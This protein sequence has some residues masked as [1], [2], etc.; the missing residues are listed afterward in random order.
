MLFSL[1]NDEKPEN[2]SM[3]N[4]HSFFASDP[5]VI[6]EHDVIASLP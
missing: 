5:Q 2:L 6:P 3:E 1:K 4:F